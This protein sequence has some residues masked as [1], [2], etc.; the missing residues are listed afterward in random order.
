V[1]GGA[2]FPDVTNKPVFRHA[3]AADVDSV[4]RTL[5]LALGWDPADPIPPFEPLVGHPEIAIYWEGWMRPGDEGVLAHVDGEFAGMA[6]CRLFPDDVPS[7]GFYDESTPELAV[8]VVLQ[9]RG[10][11]IGTALVRRLIDALTEAGVP[12]LSLSVAA[13][14]PAR[15]LYERLGFRPVTE[16]NHDVL[17]VLDLL[18]VGR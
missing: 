16:R 9:Q 4:K 3:T 7:Q 17:M 8:A 11:G 18:R 2:S 12:G 14:N 5:Y 15:R 13:A 10:R 1:L 6:Y